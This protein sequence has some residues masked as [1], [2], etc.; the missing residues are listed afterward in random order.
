MSDKPHLFIG[1]PSK[2]G[3][4]TVEL[5]RWLTAMNVCAATGELPFTITEGDVT[6]L[7]PVHFARNA[8]MK[9]ALATPA[10]RVLTIDDDMIPTE[11]TARI[12]L[13]DA[14]I[15]VSRMY[16]FRHHGPEGM[17][18]EDAKPPELAACATY[19]KLMGGKETRFDIVP[20]FDAAGLVK[21]DAVGTG[22]IS[23]KR[24]VLE[25][26]H[27]RVGPDDEDGTP[28]LYRMLYTATGR[29]TE[30]EDIDFTLRASRLGYSVAADFGSRCGHFKTVNLDAV[31]ELVHNERLAAIDEF[32]A[33]AP[34]EN[35][36]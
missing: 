31:A 36:A 21:V 26:P 30:W 6:G 13:S 18:G 27:M 28:A 15:C 8:L 11:T 25:D 5:H 32:L 19:V 20:R 24:K 3:K 33:H 29:I 23:V 35:A 16:R 10:E 2:G 4:V 9:M 14:D 1:V 17:D 7:A 34:K 22:C 12:L